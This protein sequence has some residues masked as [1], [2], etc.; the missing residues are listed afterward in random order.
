MDMSLWNGGSQSY[1]TYGWVDVVLE[2]HAPQ[3][4]LEVAAHVGVGVS[5]PDP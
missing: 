4:W 5:C 3:Q 2:E 1:S